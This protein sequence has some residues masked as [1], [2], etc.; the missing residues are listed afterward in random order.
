MGKRKG[1]QTIFYDNKVSMISGYSVVGEKEGC[2]NFK[3]YFDYIL[4]DDTFGEKSYEKAERK[5]LEF[6]IE[7]ALKK[8]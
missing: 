5:I 1:K 4:K 3:Q 8:I 2:G 7:N 6:A